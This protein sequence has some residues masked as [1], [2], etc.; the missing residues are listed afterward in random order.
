MYTVILISVLT[1]VFVVAGI[2]FGS[3]GEKDKFY[4]ATW[5]DVMMGMS[6]TLAGISAFILIIIVSL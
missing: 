3:I 4:S 2:V 5:P 1:V 6:L